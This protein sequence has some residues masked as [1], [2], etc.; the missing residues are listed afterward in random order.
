M[1]HAHQTYFRWLLQ[2]R[3]GALP[4]E[5]QQELFQHLQTCPECARL[6]A[7]FRQF[8]GLAAEFRAL[9]PPPGTFAL[10]RRSPS[11]L[12]RL[13]AR[14]R[15]PAALLAGIVLL[16]ALLV[17]LNYSIQ[18]LVPD[19]AAPGS[20]ARA[21]GLQPGRGQVT[22]PPRS[23]SLASPSWLENNT[24]LLA[25]LVFILLGGF[26]LLLQALSPADKLP[27]Y[28]LL[29]LLLAWLLTIA[30]AHWSASLQFASNFELGA[31]VF[32]TLI[33]CLPLIA[34]ALVVN[35]FI[36][37]DR[38]AGR[39]RRW[40]ALLAWGALVIGTVYLH[41]LLIDGYGLFITIFLFP[42]IAT[43]GMI[44]SGRGGRR[45]A[46]RDLVFACIV[47]LILFLFA[48]VLPRETP[49]ASFFPVSIFFSYFFILPTLLIGL[50]ARWLYLAVK[51]AQRQN[52]MLLAAQALMALLS[53]WLLISMIQVE[54]AL[55]SLSD[56]PGG[57][58]TGTLLIFAAIC[59]GV[60]L[61]WELRGPQRLSGLLFAA[62]VIA[63][64]L[65]YRFSFYSSYYY[66]PL[67]PGRITEQRAARI[68]AGLEDYHD[69][70][71]VYPLNLWQ[72]APL[73]LIYLPKPVMYADLGWCYQS[74]GGG[75]RFGYVYTPGY[76]VPRDYIELRQFSGGDPPTG[77]WPCDRQLQQ[78]RA[79]A[80]PLPPGAGD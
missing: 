48:F 46:I 17:G 5:Q 23:P 64:V 58:L 66:Q 36:W 40:H 45:E 33:R 16:V 2:A 49:D 7:H 63:M 43:A 68:L 15:Q 41:L 51:P 71:G 32:E 31:F 50:F 76:N 35:P 53:L 74:D 38:L 44:H 30:L 28:W 19:A 54:W 25:F 70:T 56:D 78:K 72:L 52:K 3:Q 73:D 37:D 22:A 62:L 47:L 14:L 34:G 9:A 20:Q 8:S 65:P 13:W 77:E 10:Q 12:P 67:D 1:S 6:Q 42:G 26:G 29:F 27:R 11:R 75:Y 18:R 24:E 39:T 69:R 79:Q 60:Y 59:A 61:L 57:G 55:G 21:P 80:P 4:P